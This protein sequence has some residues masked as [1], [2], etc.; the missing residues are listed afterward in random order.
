[1]KT[2]RFGVSILSEH[3]VP[4]SNYYAGWGVEGFEPEHVELNSIPT[5]KDS[6]TRAAC[7]VL[8]RVDAGDHTLFIAEVEAVETQEGVGEALIYYKRDYCVPRSMQLASMRTPSGQNK[9]LSSPIVKAE[10]N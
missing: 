2:E 4:V 1:M 7:R 9:T 8:S 3:Q 6:L 10:E 5:I